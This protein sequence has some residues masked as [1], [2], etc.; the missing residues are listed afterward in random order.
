MSAYSWELLHVATQD[1]I[2]REE[3]T[4]WQRIRNFRCGCSRYPSD[5]NGDRINLCQYHEGFDEGAEAA[6]RLRGGDA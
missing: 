5:A 3:S 2:E 6:D 1:S 4:L